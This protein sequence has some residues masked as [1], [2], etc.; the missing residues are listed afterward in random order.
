M[1][2]ELHVTTGSYLTRKPGLITEAE[3]DQPGCL[4]A[5]KEE[6]LAM[7]FQ[8]LAYG[9]IKGFLKLNPSRDDMQYWS[10]HS[11]TERKYRPKGLWW[12][13]PWAPESSHRTRREPP[14]TTL[15]R[16]PTCSPPLRSTP[17]QH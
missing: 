1:D 5:L 16:A 10:R 3:G 15:P 9:N 6:A 4:A 8:I 11:P 2:A 7:G 17:K 12:P 13:T 14:F